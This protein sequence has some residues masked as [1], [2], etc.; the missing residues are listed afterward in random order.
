[1]ERPALPYRPVPL[2]AD[3]RSLYLDNAARLLCRELARGGD[4]GMNLLQ[5]SWPDLARHLE[6][7][8]RVY[9]TPVI[10]TDDSTSVTGDGAVGVQERPDALSG[11]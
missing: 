6:H 10:G 2:R 1:M 8:A 3:V 4:E 9:A 7:F 5:R 11:R